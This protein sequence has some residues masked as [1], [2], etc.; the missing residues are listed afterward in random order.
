MLMELLYR[1]GQIKQPAIG[2]LLGK[3]DYSDEGAE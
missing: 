2:S 3:I 1:F